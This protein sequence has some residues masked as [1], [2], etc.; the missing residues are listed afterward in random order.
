MHPQWVDIRGETMSQKKLK[1][2]LVQEDILPEAILKTAQI[3]EILL[4][5]TVPTVNEAV[6][7]IGLSR[8]AF[9]KY[10]DG[11]FP[12]NDWKQGNIVTISLNL[13]HRSGILSNILNTIA[14]NNGNI[15]TINQNIPIHGMANV[16][17][18]FETTSLS[19]DIEHLLLNIKQM[20][21]VKKA[22]IV[23]LE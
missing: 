5:G 19:G 22:D 15:I 8:S 18:S 2:Y 9:Y 16:T 7:K 13:E 20:D 1:F 17:I 23:A 14:Q 3:K 11:I 10:K 21:G 6:E 4:K 12:F